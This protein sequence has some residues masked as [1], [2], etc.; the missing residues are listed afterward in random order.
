[1]PVGRPSIQ[2]RILSKEDINQAADILLSYVDQDPAIEAFTRQN[3]NIAVNLLCGGAREQVEPFSECFFGL[4][5]T[6]VR[7]DGSLYP[8]FRMAASR[9]R[10]FYC[11]NILEDSPLKI[12]LREL[13]IFL[14]SVRQI[15]IPEYDKCLFCVFNNALEVGLTGKFQLNQALAG[16][17]FF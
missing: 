5:K 2:E 13:Y 7:A 11:G 8:C 12:A 16:D 17:Y 3:T 15:C 4:A 1:M 9:D 6:V 14:S 10:R